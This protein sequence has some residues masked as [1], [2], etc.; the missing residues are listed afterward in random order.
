MKKTFKELKRKTPTLQQKNNK[1]CLSISH[2]PTK[3]KN[4]DKF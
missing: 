4:S 3:D 1:Q 2:I